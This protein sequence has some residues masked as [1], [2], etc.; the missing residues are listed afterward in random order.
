M[1]EHYVEKE[2]KRIIHLFKDQPNDTE[3]T[4]AKII[5]EKDEKMYEY[6][7]E[8]GWIRF[9]FLFV[10]KGFLPYVL[11]GRNDF[12]FILYKHNKGEK[13]GLR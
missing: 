6:I 4:G 11:D 3:F 5:F 13:N 2:A 10:N 8:Y 1:I 12:E 7:Q 9:L